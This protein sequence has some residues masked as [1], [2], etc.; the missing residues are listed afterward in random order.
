MGEDIEAGD[1][2]DLI[3]QSTRTFADWIAA[4]AR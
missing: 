2:R 3:R 4:P 1:Y